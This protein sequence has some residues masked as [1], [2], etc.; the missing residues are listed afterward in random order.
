MT[1][2]PP[3]PAF[4]PTWHTQ[5]AAQT[6]Q[7]QSVVAGTGLAR[8]EASRRLAQH[9]PN[10]LPAAKRR[11]SWL[12]LA[13]QFHNPLIYVLLAAGAITFGLDDHMDAGSAAGG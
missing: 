3:A 10:S 2:A 5:T 7:A 11:P 9:G 8:E 1:P 13:L 12:R 6:L 4:S